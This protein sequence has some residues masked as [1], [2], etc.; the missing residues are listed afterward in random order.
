[1]VYQ[2]RA[3]VYEQDGELSPIKLGGLVDGG[4][5]VRLYLE[6]VSARALSF[7]TDG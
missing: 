4:S 6:L 3:S 5:K 2:T 7:R 1:M